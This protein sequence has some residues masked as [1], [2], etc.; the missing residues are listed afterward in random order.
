LY[1]P[2]GTGFDGTKISRGPND[3]VLSSDLSTITAAETSGGKVAAMS[4]VSKTT[5]KYYAELKYISSTTGYGTVGV[6]PSG[7]GNAPGEGQG[8]SILLRANGTA[9]TT[10]GGSTGIDAPVGSIFKFAVDLDTDKM[11]LGY[12]DK[13]VEPTAW[14]GVVGDINLATPTFTNV[15]SDFLGAGSN[16]PFHVFVV[17][18]PGQGFELVT[19][20]S[21]F[22]YPPPVGFAAWD[23]V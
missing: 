15:N 13:W 4:L 21:D 18:A 14:S 2:S 7:N 17:A 16:Y 11:W 3:Y 5:G 23:T 10:G 6:S 1:G 8:F 19:L 12:N 22:I 9:A 20:S